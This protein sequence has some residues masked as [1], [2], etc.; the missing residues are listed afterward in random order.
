MSFRE[1]SRT[2]RADR[3]TMIISP[4]RALGFN[5]VDK[6]IAA[7]IVREAF[8]EVHD[9]FHADP[10]PEFARPRRRT[11]D[12]RSRAARTSAPMMKETLSSA[13]AI[14]MR[15]ST[16]S[17]ARHRL[18][19]S[20]DRVDIRLF[21]T[22]SP[23]CF[24]R[25]RRS[26]RDVGSLQQLLGL[27]MVESAFPRVHD[28]RACG[29]DD[30]H[31]PRVSPRHRRRGC[32][33]LMRASPHGTRTKMSKV[34]TRPYFVSGPVARRSAQL[35]QILSDLSREAR[36]SHRGSEPNACARRSFGG[37][38]LVRHPRGERVHRG[39]FLGLFAHRLARMSGVP[40][41][42]GFAE[43]ACC[44]TIAYAFFRPLKISVLR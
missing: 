28:A 34:S 26:I 1:S 42:Y 8:D 39:A 2:S 12:P 44:W 29:R 4:A 15:D 40:V 7:R 27:A 36:G 18:G 9:A 17:R 20:G 24:R 19:Q 25:P 22:T 5:D 32:R 43:S 41:Y 35:S 14:A 13:L 30:R 10:H 38:D 33:C 23:R 6:A 21:A 11:P 3:P 16:P 31:R 37:D